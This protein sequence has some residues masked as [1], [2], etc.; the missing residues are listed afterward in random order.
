MTLPCL[1]NLSSN[2]TQ[3]PHL[4]KYFIKTQLLQICIYAKIKHDTREILRGQ[5]GDQ[6]AVCFSQAFG[7]RFLTKCVY[8]VFVVPREPSGVRTR[9]GD[10]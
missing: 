6:R 10:L 4:A 7:G 5:K 2:F 8:S 1:G 3:N 9:L